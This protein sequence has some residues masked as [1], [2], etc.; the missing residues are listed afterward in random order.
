MK[1][2]KNTKFIKVGDKIVFKPTTDGLDYDLENGKAYTIDVDRYTDE[3]LFSVAPDLTLPE[4]IYS[5]NNDESFINRVLSHYNNSDCGTTGVMLAGLKGSGKTVMSK[6]IAIRSNLPIIIIDKGFSPRLFKNLFNKLENTNVCMVFDEVDKLGENYDNDYL[7]Q[8]L[9]GMNSSG[10][11]LMMFTCNNDDN[12]CEYLLDR[13][14]R[15]RYWKEF[16]E[17]DNAMIRSI[18]ED[19][20]NDK[21]EVNSLTDFIA[22][23]FGCISFDNVCSF[24]TE[25]NENP[26][27][28]YETLFN[29][30]NLSKK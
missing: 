4:K 13:C 3:I 15:I 12:I 25:I 24:A 11:K 9:D 8:V 22:N 10:K 18:L 16:D 23:N 14:S 21:T 27:N 1:E 7:L 2:N 6:N 29:D 20:L 5:T 30:M 26:T 17:M 28:T 19:K